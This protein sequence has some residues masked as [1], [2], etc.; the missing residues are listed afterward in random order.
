VL[1]PLNGGNGPDILALAELESERSAEL[2]QQALNKRLGKPELDYT[3]VLYQPITG[4]RHIAT[5]ILT[6]LPVERNRTLLLDKRRRILEGRLKVAGRPLIIIASHWTSRVSDKKGTGRAKYADIIYGRFK[7]LF[8]ANPDVDLLVCGDF[9]DN[10]DD[11]SVTE[12]LRATGD[13]EAVLASARTK[14]PLLFNLFAGPYQNGEASHYY[15][16]RRKP[17]KYLLDQICVSPGMLDEEGWSCVVDSAK[18]VRQMATADGWPK[19]FGGERE[20]MPLAAR[21]ASDHFPV[22]VELRVR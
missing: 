8:L 14:E 21:G 15:G 16:S 19:R 10:P 3:N 2:L 7:S 11:P 1:L 6:R 17:K 4:G 12:H 5:A 22:T 9:N 20:R 18:V 13:R